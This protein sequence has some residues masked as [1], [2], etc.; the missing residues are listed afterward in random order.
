MEL[1]LEYYHALPVAMDAIITQ[2]SV[3]LLEDFIHWSCGIT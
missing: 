1:L 3:H 2:Y